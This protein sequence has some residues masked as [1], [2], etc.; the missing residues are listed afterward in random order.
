MQMLSSSR[1]IHM[2]RSWCIHDCTLST[3]YTQERRSENAEQDYMNE[4]WHSPEKSTVTRQIDQFRERESYSGGVSLIIFVDTDQHIRWYRICCILHRVP[5]T[6]NQLQDDWEIRCLR[7][8]VSSD[9]K[10]ITCEQKTRVSRVRVRQ[11]PACIQD[12]S[13]TLSRQMW[14]FV[15]PS[16]V[17]P[18]QWP[19]FRSDKIARLGIYK[20]NGGETV[21]VSG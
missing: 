15:R 13:S 4:C 9:C 14:Q 11:C 16:W 8:M 3:A 12:P 2:L 7:A 17:G 10:L 21:V 5:H 19:S 20:N 1:F 6:L 18:V